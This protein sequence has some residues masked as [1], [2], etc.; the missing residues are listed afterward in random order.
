[1]KI[2]KTFEEFVNENEYQDW[3]KEIPADGDSYT[4]HTITQGDEKVTDIVDSKNDIS[5]VH[6]GYDGT[7]IKVVVTKDGEET[8][9]PYPKN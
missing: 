9:Y 7:T 4:L 1:M 3:M 6:S 8:S 5:G 2:L